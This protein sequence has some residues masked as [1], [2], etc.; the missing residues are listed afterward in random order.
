M[1][2]PDRLLTS[3]DD[4]LVVFAGAGVSAARPTSLP[5]WY[6]LNRRILGALGERID[7][8]IGRPGYSQAISEAVD[9]RRDTHRFPP[10]FQA[11]ILHELCGEDYF[12]ALQAVDLSVRSG[13]HEAI[14]WLGAHGVLAGVVTTNFDRLI[15][16]AFAAHGVETMVAYEEAGCA[17]VVAALDAER[18][19]AVPIVKIHGCVKDHRSLIDTLQQRLRG[20]YAT[21][22]EIVRRWLAR[23]YWLYVGFSAN[24]LETDEGYLG[25]AKHAGRSPGCTYLSWPDN[26]DL[27]PGAERLLASYGRKADPVTAEL[28][29]VVQEI[30]RTRGWGT[31]PVP[32][33]P[34]EATSAAV[35]SHLRAWAEGLHPA[36][37]VNCLAGV[38]EAVGEAVV[39]FQLLHRF[40]K[41]VRGSERSGPDFERFRYLHGRLGMGQGHLSLARDHETEAGRES[42]QNLLRVRHEEGRSVA[43]AWAG[44]AFAWSGKIRRGFPLLQASIDLLRQRLAG[45]VGDRVG[46]SDQVDD[47]LALAEALFVIGEPEPLLGTWRDT[48]QLAAADGDLPRRAL[49]NALGALLLAEFDKDSYPKFRDGE[50][51]GVMKSAG[52]LHH[53]A[54]EGFSALAEGRYWTKLIKGERAVEPFHRAAEALEA[55]AR[56][57]WWLFSVIQY[58]KALMDV[59]EHDQADKQLDAICDDVDRYPVLW[60]WFAEARGQWCRALGFTDHAR[61]NFETAV[62]RAEEMNL[63]RRADWLRR[64]LKDLPPAAAQAASPDQEAATLLARGL[65]KAQG[66]DLEGA[67]ADYTG[68][69]DMTDASPELRAPALNNRALIRVKT[70]DTDGALADY[71]A[72]IEM[73]DAPRDQKAEARY[74]RGEAWVQAGDA[75]RAL[76]DLVP[77]IES[78]DAPSDHR[79]YALIFRGIT[80]A[81]SGD[82]S[83]AIDDFTSVVDMAEA[84]ADH[85]AYALNNRATARRVRG[86]TSG[87]VADFTAVLE[88]REAPPDELTKAEKGL[89]SLANAEGR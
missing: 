73:P 36:A 77:V 49:V 45:S 87:A 13:G 75:D 83:G 46:V 53:P 34:R 8:Y 86:D 4:G 44:L 11:Q 35:E 54:V 60:L 1:T 85:R 48:A 39:A 74:R 17:D 43:G 63:R 89:A 65:T 69:I 3:L 7:I 61:Q 72:V 76:E 2:L 50:L 55:A 37:A 67:K 12:R 15:E 40:W 81:Q 42:L 79:T 64:N 28:T 16:Q 14:A 88:I 52:R 41:D 66:G 27:T 18:I 25:I 20:R 58:C 62:E 80:R 30:G 78:S 5:G 51:A 26:P 71:T 47:W 9:Q 59:G 10:D 38:A 24:D 21:R 32:P 29:D 70:G 23:H 68:V 31:A 22:D 82:M 84:P 19:D 56:P 57:P 6:A 33:A